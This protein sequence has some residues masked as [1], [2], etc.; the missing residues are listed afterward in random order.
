MITLICFCLTWFTSLL[1]SKSRL[2]AENAI[3]RHQLTVLQRSF[4]GRARLSNGDR[5]FFVLLY[6]WFPSA[7]KVV[8]IVRPRRSCAGTEPGF[9]GT[10]VGNRA[11]WEDG[12]RSMLTCGH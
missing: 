11:R 9:A 8:T 2:E 12:R 4:H 10:G 6:R 3:L 7:L 5:L 1:R